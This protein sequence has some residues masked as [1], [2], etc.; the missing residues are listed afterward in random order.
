MG[1]GGGVDIKHAFITFQ[2]CITYTF[3]KKNWGLS[4]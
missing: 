2:T 4:M 3:L 1:W